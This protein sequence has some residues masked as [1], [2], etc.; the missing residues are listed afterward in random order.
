MYSSNASAPN[1]GILL[2][3]AILL[4]KGKVSAGTHP[5]IVKRGCSGVSFISLPDFSLSLIILSV[6]LLKNSTFCVGTA[7]SLLFNAITKFSSFSK[8]LI[9]LTEPSPKV[10]KVSP[11]RHF[12]EP[13]FPQI[14]ITWLLATSKYTLLLNDVVFPIVTYNLPRNINPS[15][16]K[17]SLS[18]SSLPRIMSYILMRTFLNI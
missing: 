4:P 3:V 10:I 2:G 5:F 1:T 14:K 12:P 11:S 15:F 7:L 9:A 8:S 6:F 13:L 16:P 17:S 18:A